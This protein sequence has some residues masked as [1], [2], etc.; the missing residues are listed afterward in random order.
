[1]KPIPIKKI[2]ILVTILAVPGFLYYLLQ[3]QG[4]NRYKPLPVM[5]P[6][7]VASTFHTK[8]G[9]QI[10]DTIFHQAGDFQLVSQNAKA[11]SWSSYNNKIVLVYLFYTKGNYS[12]DV[13]NKAIA[14][15]HESYLKNERIQFLGLTIDP[16][17]DVPEVLGNYAKNLYR[18]TDRWDLLTGD[19]AQLY[20]FINKQLFI[21][22]IQEDSS[23][24]PQFT[25]SNMIVLLDTQH[26]IRGYYDA[27]NLEMLAKLDDEI[28]VLIAEELRNTKDGR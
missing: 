27:T 9:V 13:V 11:V 6:K 19:S 24:G 23:E 8:R 3:D 17:N 28:K 2:L 7:Q 15:L 5:G 1:M 26:R 25:Y 10:P 20:H 18:N 12:V 16:K 4:K 22:A 21:D 14:A